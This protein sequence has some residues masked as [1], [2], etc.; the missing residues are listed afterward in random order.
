ME[1]FIVD[2]LEKCK[3][4][5]IVK[6]GRQRKARKLNK[7]LYLSEQFEEFWESISRRTTY[8]VSV[9]R[10]ELI[11]KSISTIKEAPQIQP[12]RIQVTR[13]GLKILRGAAKG[14]ELGTR[15]AD[16]KRGYA[17]PDIITEL[18]EATSLT[19]RTI[20]DILL[21]S[22]RLDEFLS[23]PNDYIKMVKDAVQAELARIV[24]EGV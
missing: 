24:V 22:G 3:I 23:N 20:I 2:I 19:R 21:G 11:E 7:E 18:Q 1:S 5:K 14:E 10:E 6:R 12:L 8:S 15:S 9:D 4:E 13:A 17:L 16:L